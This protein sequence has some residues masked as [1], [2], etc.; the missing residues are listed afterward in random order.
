MLILHYLGLL[1]RSKYIDSKVKLLT[2]PREVNFT[3]LI[4]M[5]KSLGFLTN[6]IFQLLADISTFSKSP[7]FFTHPQI[8]RRKKKFSGRKSKL[9]HWKKH[10]IYRFFSGLRIAIA[11]D[12][13]TMY[14]ISTNKNI[15]FKGMK[16]KLHSWKIRRTLVPEKQCWK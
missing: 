13:N 10:S 12:E 2:S 15:T 6:D 3:I 8:R 16:S 4:F 1:C 9:H 7:D 5:S 14:I 11:R